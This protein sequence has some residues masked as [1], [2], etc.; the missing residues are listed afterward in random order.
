M[1]IWTIFSFRRTIPARYYTFSFGGL[2]D[3]FAL[4]STDNTE[5]GPPAPQY[6]PHSP[7]FV[8]MQQAVMGSRAAGKIPYFH[9]PPFTAGPAHPSSFS[10][11]HHWL[12]L[13]ERSGVKRP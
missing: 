2:A 7:E 4:D 5:S 1:C 8:W 3:F 6:G 12:R 13:F 11:L 9:H 10:E